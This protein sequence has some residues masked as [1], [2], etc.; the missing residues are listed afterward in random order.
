MIAY[1]PAPFYICS[2]TLVHSM[3]ITKNTSCIVWSECTIRILSCRYIFSSTE[4]VLLHITF[5]FTTHQN[6]FTIICQYHYIIHQNLYPN[7]YTYIGWE[8]FFNICCHLEIVYIYSIKCQGKENKMFHYFRSCAISCLLYLQYVLST[9]TINHF[10]LSYYSEEFHYIDGI[11]SI[12]YL[13]MVVRLHVEER[14]EWLHSVVILC[15]SPFSTLI[16]FTNHSI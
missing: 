8:S 2:C 9:I 6:I 11:V 10:F 15:N 3:S 13:Q 16:I 1:H 14:P 7:Q 4:R 12:L 5:T